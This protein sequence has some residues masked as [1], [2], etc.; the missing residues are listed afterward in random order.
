MGENRVCFVISPIGEDDSDIRRRSD[1]IFKYII[2]PVSQECGY[3][4]VR[5]DKISRP[6]M[7]TSQIIQHLL[8]DSL[9]IADLTGQNPNVFYEL[10]I[11]HAVR[12]PYI[13][14]V[15][16]GEA[17]PFDISQSR[18]I[19]IDHRDLD[20]VANCKEEMIRQIKSVQEGPAIDNPITHAIDLQFLTRS[21]NLL[22]KSNA[23]IM[24]M[25]QDLNSNLSEFKNNILDRVIY[26]ERDTINYQELLDS[27][28]LI[29]RGHDMLLNYKE[30]DPSEDSLNEA[31]STIRQ[32]V[33]DGLK[34]IHK[35][36]KMTKAESLLNKIKEFN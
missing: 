12:K 2:I 8:D 36:R 30:I 21:D 10:A 25:I 1:Q 35:A 24:S 28:L 20:D 23:D 9:V 3:E 5:A 29:Y 19:Y 11:R 4:A 7:I 34:I 33:S 17:I 15:K 18:T 14:I 13:Q 31:I 26:L 27:L 22:E 16:K 6:G 32:G